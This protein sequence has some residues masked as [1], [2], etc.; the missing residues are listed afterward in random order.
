MKIVCINDQV[1]NGGIFS[2]KIEKSDELTAGKMYQAELF[3]N[4]QGQ[5]TYTNPKFFI[6]NDKNEWAYYDTELFKPGEE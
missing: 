2:T 6:F 1:D 5:H 3:S 4:A